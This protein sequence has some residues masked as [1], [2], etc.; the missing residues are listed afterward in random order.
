MSILSPVFFAFLTALLIAYYCS[1]K[2]Y[3]WIALLLASLVFYCWGGRFKPLLYIGTTSFSTW[4]AAL[5]MERLSKRTKEYLHLNTKLEPKEKK[6]VKAR[7]AR[8]RKLI[9]LVALVLNLL[10][11]GVIKYT[12]FALESLTRVWNALAGASAAPVKIDF[13]VPLGISYYTFQSIG[14]LIDIYQGK[15]AAESN[16]GKYALFVTWFPQIIQG[17]IGRYNHLG[18]QLTAPNSFDPQNLK[19]GAI[20]MLWGGMKKMVIANHLAPLVTGVRGN[21]A[22]FDGSLIVLATL[23][24]C[25][26]LYA[27]FS[28]GIDMVRGASELFGIKLADNFKRPYFA[29]SLGDFWRRWHISLGAWMRDYVF[30]PFAMSKRT[31]NLSRKIKAGN[32]YLAK[33]FPAIAGNVVVFLIVGLWHGAE[34]QFVLWGLYNG[35]ILGA[36]VLMEPLFERFHSKFSGLRTSAIWRGFQIARTFL[37]VWIGNYF[38]CCQGIRD[39]FVMMKRSVFDFHL[40]ALSIDAIRNLG[41][42]YRGILGL[43]IALPLLLIVSCAQERG[44]A[45][46]N[47]L[48]QRNIAVRWILLYGLIFFTIAFAATGFDAL[49]G[50]MY[51]IF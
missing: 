46:R 16:Y 6:A 7:C 29:A 25:F 10:L 41:I 17:P 9:F 51:E 47:W 32:K 1:P 2:R 31:M 4:L 20:L 19:R 3:R 30:Y 48:D 34:W 37:I 21:T 27:D 44:V 14:Y 26:Q 50:F 43:A 28:G 13:L 49:E 11:L 5:M 39:A 23:A 12:N 36:S 15:Y 24:Y 38:D 8:N 33:A 42:D 40:S 18:P 35:V 45:V 22:N